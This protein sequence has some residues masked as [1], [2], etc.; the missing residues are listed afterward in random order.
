MEYVALAA[1]CALGIVF[2]AAVA[3]KVRGREAFEAFRRSV[4]A[5]VP[6]PRG[7]V[8]AALPA[9]VVAVES[10]TVLLLTTE[11]TAPAGLGLAGAVLLAF[12]LGIR[13][14]LRSGS[15]TPCNCFSTSSAPLSSRHL[16]RNAVLIA[17]AVTGLAASFAQASSAQAGAQTHPAGAVLA[18]AAGGLIALFAVFTDDLAD[19]LNPVPPPPR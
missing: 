16:V 6:L 11:F 13:Y 14:A 18:L 5:L 2:L 15:R 4:P 8:Q 3:G 9:T 7:R 1:R 12:S 19:L 17:V 10:A